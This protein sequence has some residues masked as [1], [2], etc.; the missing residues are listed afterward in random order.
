MSA[1]LKP[2]LMVLIELVLTPRGNDMYPGTWTR[3]HRSPDNN[4]PYLC[5][6][7]KSSF[8]ARSLDASL[9]FGDASK[10]IKS[11]DCAKLEFFM[12]KM[13]EGAVL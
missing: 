6:F 5:V 1:L 9:S 12:H 11:I 2:G 3:S 13:K 4:L 10:V 8:F 7:S